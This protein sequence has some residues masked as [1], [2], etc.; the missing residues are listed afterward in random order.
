[1]TIGLAI[2]GDP[3]RPALARALFDI[4][5]GYRRLDAVRLYFRRNPAVAFNA[6]ARSMDVDLFVGVAGDVY[7]GEEELSR[8]LDFPATIISASSPLTPRK[9]DVVPYPEPWTSQEDGPFIS[10]LFRVPRSLL[11]D[12][13]FPE[14]PSFVEDSFFDTTVRGLGLSKASVQVP[15]V[16]VDAHPLFRARAVKY[17]FFQAARGK[18]PRYLLRMLA[19][20]FQDVYHAVRI[21]PWAE[22]VYDRSRT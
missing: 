22:A 2:C 1:M 9:A 19:W 3:R 20:E 15:C 7:V 5:R 6:A 17:L 8:F 21:V 13:P 14:D 10:G 11:L 12:H 18:G 16:H 4:Y